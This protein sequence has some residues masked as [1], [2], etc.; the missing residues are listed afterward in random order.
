MKQGVFV[1]IACL[2]M[3]F[4]QDTMPEENSK[5]RTEDYSTYIGGPPANAAITYTLLGGQATLVSHIGDSLMGKLIKQELTGKYGIRVVDLAEGRDVMPSVSCIGINTLN[6][7]RTIWSGQ[8]PLHELTVDRRYDDVV[9][10]ADFCLTDCNLKEISYAVAEA[11][12]RNG[13]TVVLDP[14][15]W[16]TH[17]PDFLALADEVIAPMECKPVGYD[18]DLFALSKEKGVASFAVTDGS[19]SIWW[20]SQ[21]GE[22]FI[23]PPSVEAVDTLGAGDIFHGAFCYFRFVKEMDFAAS[24]REAS[25]V[26][27]ESVTKKG[28]REGVLE[29]MRKTGG[30]K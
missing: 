1:G 17:T 7:N 23:D 11:A 25:A 12:A 5:T 27:A 9:K 14:G 20:K 4:Y 21:A 18:M 16:K 6:G 19:S 13:V 2:D 15:S 29:Y 24:L 22:G 26:A 10:D 30:N 28:P 8:P 3:A